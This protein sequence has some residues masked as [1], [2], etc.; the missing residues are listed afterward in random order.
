MDYAYI[1][2]SMYH[3][4][5][6][7]SMVESMADK[8]MLCFFG[9]GGLGMDTL[10]TRIETLSQTMGEKPNWGTN[11]LANPNKPDQEMLIAETLIR[12]N[13]PAI[14]ASAFTHIQPS[15]V[16]F[17]FAGA[18]R[19][20]D[21]S[22][23]DARRILAKLSRTE[24]AERFMQPAPTDVIDQ[25]REDGLLTSEEAWC[26]ARLPVAQDICMESDSG[27]HTDMASALTALPAMLS[28]RDHMRTETG[29]DLR[30]GAAGGLGSS[31]AIAAV[32][33][34]GADFVL[35]G[36]INQCTP[37]AGT[38]DA[39]KD[40]LG[41]LGME[42]TA[43]CPSGDMFELGAMTQ[44]VSKGSFFPARARKLFELY[45]Q[46]DSLED[47]P[48]QTMKKLEKRF[49]RKPVNQVW[50]EVAK[51]LKERRPEML[52]RAERN[53][54]VRMAQVFRWYFRETSRM[55]LSGNMDDPTNLQIHCGPAMGSFNTM[56]R[57]T[58][59]EDWRNRHVAD[60]GFM[61]MEGAAD[62]LNT[63]LNGNK[64]AEKA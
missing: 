46:H 26:A 57:G 19:G 31:K 9:T 36:S 30:V 29:F 12:H 11:L 18:K 17:R 59:M 35:T 32:F 53:G 14:E 52:E 47:I 21:G 63:C 5:S 25:L 44:V 24:V 33:L 61:L 10:E 49:F 27:G 3:G 38:S 20:A 41:S 8:G 43:Y 23:Q 15:V 40:I 4:I 22:V 1:G 56:V 6:S 34:M 54:R 7:E 16:L 39:I 51:T 45:R 2:G 13:V 50:A 58:S 28:L 64:L 60:I 55:A 37:E 62:T 48:A 42:D